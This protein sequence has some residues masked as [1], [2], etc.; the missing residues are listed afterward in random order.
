VKLSEVF[1][2]LPKKLPPEE[3]EELS[4]PIAFMALLHMANEKTLELKG[5]N[6]YSDIEVTMSSSAPTL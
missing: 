6:D 2:E 5:N 3:V 1:R 4:F